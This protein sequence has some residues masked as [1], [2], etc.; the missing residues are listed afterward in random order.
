[1]KKSLLIFLMTT[2]IFVLV[3]CSSTNTDA[4]V[5]TVT[6]TPTPTVEPVATE[7]KPTADTTASTLN[8]DGVYN[9]VLI[10]AGDEPLNVLKTIRNESGLDLAGAKA[11]V[12]NVPSVIAEQ[13]TL[14]EAESLKALV[15]TEGGTIELQE[16]EKVAVEAITGSVNVVLTDSGAAKLNVVKTLRDERGLDLAGAKALVDTIPSVIAEN[17]TIEE[18]EALKAV[19]EAVGATVEIEQ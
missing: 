9:V 3:A 5:A 15:E 8:P 11:L 14:E 2:V 13:L 6:P 1:M 19:L 17:I 7:T 10:A 4:P 18:A 16:T 12:D